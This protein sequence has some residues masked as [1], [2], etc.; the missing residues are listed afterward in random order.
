MFLTRSMTE[1]HTPRQPGTSSKLWVFPPEQHFNTFKHT[2]LHFLY[3]FPNVL[4]LFTNIKFLLFL[5]I[6]SVFI[7]FDLIFFFFCNLIFHLKHTGVYFHFNVIFYKYF[8]LNS[9]IT[10]GGKNWIK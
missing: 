6:K 8:L 5:K 7:S 1:T 3:Y 4:L 2:L 10:R 9:G